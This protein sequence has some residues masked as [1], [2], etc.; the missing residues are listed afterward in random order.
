MAT[1]KKYSSDVQRLSYISDELKKSARA[2]KCAIIGANQ[3]N[4][5]GRKRHLKGG[6]MDTIDSA[7]SDRFGHDCDIMI[8]INFDGANLIQMIMI[9]SRDSEKSTIYLRAEYGIMKIIWDET[10]TQQMDQDL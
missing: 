5:E 4:R 10:L 1:D 9:K 6:Q 8:G 7:F 3:I 2:L